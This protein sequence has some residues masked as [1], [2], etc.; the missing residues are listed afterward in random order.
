[1]RIL[2]VRGYNLGSDVTLTLLF[3]WRYHLMSPARFSILITLMLVVAGA[4]LAQN[5]Q[6][7]QV[8]IKDEQPVIVEPV[9]P[10]DPVRRINYTPTGLGVTV[11]TI[12]DQTLHLSHFPTFHFDGRV[13]PQGQ[14][15]RA[16]FVNRPLPKGKSPREGFMSA[17]IVGDLRVTVTV[18]LVPTKPADKS[19]KR[20][21]DSVLVHYLIENKGQKPHKF[22]LRVYMDTYVIDNDGCQFAA[23][24]MPGKILNGV[25]LKEKQL[26]PYVQLL[27]RPDL[28]NPGYVAHLTLDLGSRLEKPDRVVLT[29]HGAGGAF[30]G[31]D[32]PAQPAGDTALGV[33]W[34][35]K[36]I[37]PGGK[38]EIAYGYGKGIVTSPEHEGQ[39]KLALGGSF[40]P[41]KLFDITAY[42]SDPAPGQ[43]LTLELPDGMKLVE[44]KECQPVPALQGEEVN[45][46]VL[47]R[48][49]VARPGE[50]AVRVRSS[51]GVTQGKLIS[52]SQAK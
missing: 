19:A 25:L 8:T 28:K 47:W 39:V 16:E 26:P 20:Q 22:G 12:N 43:F 35:P 10:V 23:P 2:A 4:A 21:L 11:R 40:E 34:E 37:K 33:F 48:A 17:Y 29:Q 7:V 14:E 38:R 9:L 46:L 45:S 41:G 15:A 52:V 49:R 3:C 36:E 50:F 31:W 30:G 42:V 24:T 18:T 13:L 32:M 44:G 27:Q 51:T 5:T 6:P 1:L